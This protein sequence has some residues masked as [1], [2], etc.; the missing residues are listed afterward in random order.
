M[1]LLHRV[2]VHIINE[3]HINRISLLF[4]TTFTP[5][6]RKERRGALLLKITKIRSLVTVTNNYFPDRL[7]DAIKTNEGKGASMRTSYR[8]QR[9]GSNLVR[10]FLIIV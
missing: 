6:Y 5:I 7:L 3:N 4:K 10:G 1:Q 9:F 8:V 2:H